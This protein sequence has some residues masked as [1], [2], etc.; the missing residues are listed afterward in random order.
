[1][2]CSHTS[3]ELLAFP[4]ALSQAHHRSNIMMMSCMPAG[5]ATPIERGL[6]RVQIQVNVTENDRSALRARFGRASEFVEAT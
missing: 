2:C 6:S 1:M 5:P 3:M 4:R